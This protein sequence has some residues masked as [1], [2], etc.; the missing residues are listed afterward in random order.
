MTPWTYTVEMAETLAGKLR[1]LLLDSGI[2][3]DV[4]RVST[5]PDVR[6]GALYQ[7]YVHVEAWAAG[8]GL[9]NELLAIDNQRAAEA[10][11]MEMAEKAAAV[12]AHPQIDE[13]V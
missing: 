11:A 5:H 10:A 13:Q 2:H 9:Y 1:Q 6:D 8:A 4:L 3:P 7:V 12:D